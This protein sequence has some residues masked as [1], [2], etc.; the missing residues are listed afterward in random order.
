MRHIRPGFSQALFAAL[1]AMLAAGLSVSALARDKRPAD[2]KWIR[3]PVAQVETYA[4]RA[5][6]ESFAEEMA[7]RG[8]DSNWVRQTLDE[9]QKLESVIRAARPA[10]DGQRKNWE[11]YRER[12]AGSART[13][14]GRQFMA[15]HADA[16]ARASNQYGVPVDVI[17]GI[18]GVETFYGRNTGRYRVVDSLATLAFDYPAA[19]G[20]DRSAYFREQLAQFFIWCAKEQC[21]PLEVMGS[22]AGAIGM[23]QFMPENI[24]RYGTDFDGDGHIDMFN[25]VDAIGSVARFLALHGWVPHLAPV[26]QINLGAAQFEPLLAPDILPT[27]RP[28]QLDDLGVQAL[29][30]LPP[31]EK[32]AVVKLQN[33]DNCS[34]YFLG[35]QNFYVLTRYNRSAYYAMAVLTLGQSVV[36]EEPGT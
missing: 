13:E 4:G 33:G 1:L 22:Y 9:A 26:F 2:R 32:Y 20:K 6:A 31:W 34:E 18:L 3:P 35:S 23:P 21:R 29:L 15:E 5:Q 8:L 10:A 27:F 24:R 25:P 16:L 17:L 12:F 7:Q 14:A 19:D 30:P 11:A 28:W 36:G